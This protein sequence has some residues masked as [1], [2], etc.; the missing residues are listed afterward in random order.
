M[1]QWSVKFNEANSGSI[2][3][4][5]QREFA[6][7][8][9][10]DT[11]RTLVRSVTRSGAADVVRD[12]L[13]DPTETGHSGVVAVAVAAGDLAPVESAGGAV[14]VPPAAG[15]L[16]VLEAGGLIGN[17]AGEGDYLMGGEVIAA[18]PKI[19]AQMVKELSP[20]RGKSRLQRQEPPP[21]V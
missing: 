16:L 11:V 8:G 13:L 10:P 9:V 2:P 5:I 18:N 19:F 14:A 3:G 21:A 17:L 1:A 6:V 15:S 4:E 7:R 12:V 20:Y